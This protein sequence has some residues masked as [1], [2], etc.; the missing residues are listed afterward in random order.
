LCQNER[1]MSKYADQDRTN[2]FTFF[3]RK[4]I[5]IHEQID[6]L[7]IKTIKDKFTFNCWLTIDWHLVSCIGGLAASTARVYD[8]YLVIHSHSI[9][10]AYSCLCNVCRW[11]WSTGKWASTRNI[12]RRNVFSIPAEVLD[13]IRRAWCG[14]ASSLGCRWMWHQQTGII[15]CCMQLRRGN[16]DSQANCYVEETY[17]AVRNAIAMRFMRWILMQFHEHCWYGARL[18]VR[19]V[20]QLCKLASFI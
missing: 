18:F 7:L 6:S 12:Q 3:N 14:T 20:S 8:L 15:D 13:L 4:S 5:N 19:A 1:V 10:R 16:V 17:S 11:T 9:A 2:K